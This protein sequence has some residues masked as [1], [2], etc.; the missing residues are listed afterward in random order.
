MSHGTV[1]PIVYTSNLVILKALAGFGRAA[2]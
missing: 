2:L 1:H